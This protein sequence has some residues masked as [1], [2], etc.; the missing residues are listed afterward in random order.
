MQ[1]G[2]V[3]FIYNCAD[4]DQLQR[5]SGASLANRSPYPSPDD[6]MPASRSLTFPPGRL[7]QLIAEM[8]WTC[9]DFAQ[10]MDVSEFTAGQWIRGKSKPYATKLPRFLEIFGLE[11]ELQLYDQRIARKFSDKGLQSIGAGNPDLGS[12]LV[13]LD[14]LAKHRMIFWD[15]LRLAYARYSKDSQKKD[16]QPL[17]EL[18][19]IAPPPPGLPLPQDEHLVDY[20]ARFGKALE[21]VAATMYRFARAVYPAFA[22]GRL[23][24]DFSIVPP[25]HFRAF[26][27]ARMDHAKVWNRVG[28][29]VYDQHIDLSKVLEVCPGFDPMVNLIC[30]LEIALV[31]WCRDRGP[32]KRYLFHLN[33]EWKAHLKKSRRS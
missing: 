12:L 8:D 1:G 22:A 16:W 9:K 3:G 25:N 15:S 17:Q 18:A 20:P 28:K 33:R 23:L 19:N 5:K 10:L 24:S 21:G 27:I 26:H 11:S 7:A 30:Y 31:Q 2:G 13:R 4:K 32:G 29:L 6:P 14:G